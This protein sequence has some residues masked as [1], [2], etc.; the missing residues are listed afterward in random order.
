MHHATEA[1]VA[2][3]AA[4][5]PRLV[6]APH[7]PSHA[8]EARAYTHVQFNATSDTVTL[9][10]AHMREAMARAVCGDD[11]AGTDPT[12]NA[13]QRMLAQLTGKEAALFL[14]SGTQ[15]N[16]LALH[17]HVTHWGVPVSILCDARAHVHVHETGGL[18]YHSR[19]TTQP[20]APR[21]GHHLTR[22]DVEAHAHI[23][24]DQYSAPTRVVALENTL[25]G[26]IFP[27][28][29]IRRIAAWAAPRGVVL[30]LDGARLWHVAAETGASLRELCAPFVTVSLCLSKGL[31]APVGSVLVGPAALLER[32]RMFRKLFGGG[33][34]QSGVLAAAAHVALYDTFP[35]LRDTHALARRLAARLAASGIAILVPVETNMVLF[36]VRPAGIAPDALAA[37]AAALEPPIAVRNGRLVVHWQTS[38]E[39]PARLGAL[40]DQLRPT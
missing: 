16:Q 30:H 32:V 28:D 11:V 9:P 8:D 3:G 25:H 35:R 15:A 5:T 39:L 40:I 27:Q 33:M 12:T 2:A 36:D 4:A 22:E 18:A 34:R 38:D 10:S 1:A 23:D 26:L 14:P 20:V 21:N 19:A 13:L 29:E 24:A 6:D 31:G 37:R 17:A 7:L